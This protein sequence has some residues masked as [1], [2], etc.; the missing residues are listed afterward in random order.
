[1]K[2]LISWSDF[3]KLDIRS[4]TILKAEQNKSAKKPAYT[5]QIDF[6]EELGKKKTSAQITELYQL[7]D[8][9]GLQV[10]AIVNFPP[11]QIGKMM[12]ECLILGFYTQNGV[13][14]ATPTQPLKN[15]SVLG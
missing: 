14:L 11:K 8:L 5:L 7:E 2:P 3:E 10:M 13:V 12:S 4:G 1:M 6:G 9:I 15:G